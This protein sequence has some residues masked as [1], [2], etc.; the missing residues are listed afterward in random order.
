VSAFIYIIQCSWGWV[1][2]G[3]DKGWSPITSFPTMQTITLYKNTCHLLLTWSPERL[4]LSQCLSFTRS[5]NYSCYRKAAWTSW[6]WTDLSLKDCWEIL[7]PELW[8]KNILLFFICF[9]KKLSGIQP[10]KALTLAFHNWQFA[11]IQFKGQKINAGIYLQNL[12]LSQLCNWRS[13]PSRSL[14]NAGC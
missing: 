3:S 12:K 10:T 4:F 8:R 7:H 1:L 13:K 2:D 6:S 9:T 11:C 5:Q 14:W